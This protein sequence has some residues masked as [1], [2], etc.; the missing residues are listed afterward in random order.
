MTW[1]CPSWH[2]QDGWHISPHF[3]WRRLMSCGAKSRFLTSGTKKQHRRARLREH[4]FANLQ[5]LWCA[6]MCASCAN[7][8]LFCHFMTTMLN[9]LI[10]FA[11]SCGTVCVG[12]CT[13]PKFDQHTGSVGP[14]VGWLLVPTRGRKASEDRLHTG[15]LRIEKLRSRR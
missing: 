3:I 5:G 4:V 2:H 10:T 6:C 8:G 11:V 9:I 7:P 13:S 12:S 14:C 15:R 1:M